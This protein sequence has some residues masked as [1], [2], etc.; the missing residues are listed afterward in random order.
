MRSVSPNGDATLSWGSSLMHLA[1]LL[2]LTRTTDAAQVAK[3][4]GNLDFPAVICLDRYGSLLS[5]QFSRGTLDVYSASSVDDTSFTNIKSASFLVFDQDKGLDVLGTAPK[6]EEMFDLDSAAPEAPVYV[7]DTNELWIGGL[8]TGVTSQTVVDLSQNPPKPVKRT[9]NPPIY[10]ANGMR[11]RDGRVWVSAAGGN[12]TLAGGPYHPG[13]Y[14]FDPKTGDSRVEANNYYGWYIN[15]ANDLDIDPSGQVWFTDPLYSRNMGVNTEA[16]L[17]QAAVYRYNPVSGQ[18]QVMDDTL[19][20]PNGIAF[21]PDGKILYLTN[22]A[23]G[24]GNIDPGTPWQNAGALKYVSTNKRTLYAFD[25]GTDGLLRNRRPLYTAMDY[26]ADCVKVA[27]NGYLVTA[28]GHG[29]DILDPTGVHLMRIQLNFL[30]VSVE[31]AGPQRD[32]LW[33]IGHGKAA[34]ATINLTGQGASTA[35]ARRRRHTRTHAAR[36][37][38][39]QS[40][41]E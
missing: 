2:L 26:V 6:V 16:P 29:V 1:G 13:I 11:Y 10:A 35:S 32:S 31:F 27:S 7:P 30:A 4:C 5:G 22:T 3:K 15:S 18:I 21:S 20:F 19:E 12:D 34:R 24:V 41:S 37:P 23:A 25:V 33:I 39:H 14:S 8:Q 38:A 28:A 36:H 17:L 9:L 40:I